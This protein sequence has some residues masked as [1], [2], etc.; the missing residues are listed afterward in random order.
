M[1]VVSLDNYRNEK[2]DITYEDALDILANLGN[3]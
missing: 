1:T 3:P 2:N